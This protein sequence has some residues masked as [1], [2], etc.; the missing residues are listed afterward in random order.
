MVP[1]TEFS[2]G[3]QYCPASLRNV[4]ILL[5]NDTADERA[6]FAN[7]LQQQG[8]RVYLASNEGAIHKAI[9]VR[10]DV[11]LMD[12]RMPLLN[13]LRVCGQ[14][15][16]N[17]ATR[18]I[19]VIFLAEAA[20]PTE[21]VLG[22]RSGATDYITKPFDF[23]EVRL[24]LN[25]HLRNLPIPHRAP[26]PTASAAST[27]DQVLCTSAQQVL[28]GEIANDVDMASLSKKVCSNPRRLNEAFKHCIGMTVFEFL[29]E[30]RM[31]QAQHLLTATL[32]DI[33]IVAN[34][35]GFT[36]GANFATAFKERFGLSPTAFRHTAGQPEPAHRTPSKDLAW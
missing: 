5:I 34:E 2:L 19:P 29:R 14:L 10:P 8:Y 22:L 30:A 24:R 21:R 13:G 16:G 23:E 35:V 6:A 36:S 20:A 18:D 33:Q 3:S 12:T 32:L 28:L 9:V 15:K 27:L 7:Y 1:P 11:I 17:P 31:K 25:I 4:R 26:Q